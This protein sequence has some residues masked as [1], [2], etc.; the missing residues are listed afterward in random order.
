MEI[1]IMKRNG[2]SDE[3]RKRRDD[4]SEGKTVAWMQKG[5]CPQRGDW[6]GKATVGSVSKASKGVGPVDKKEGKK[7]HLEKYRT[8]RAARRG[9]VN[10]GTERRVKKATAC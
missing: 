8:R 6:N 2:Q 5:P 9:D 7:K 3:K 1:G 4:T 10:C